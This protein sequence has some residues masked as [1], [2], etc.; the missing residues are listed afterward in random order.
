[1]KSRVPMDG[2]RFI[3]VHK[4]ALQLERAHHEL[5]KTVSPSPSSGNY[6]KSCSTEIY[7]KVL[8]SEL[9]GTSNINLKILEF[10]NN[11][12]DD[13]LCRKKRRLSVFGEFDIVPSKTASQRHIST[14]PIAVYDV[15]DIENDYYLN[16]VNWHPT[17]NL[18]AV[19]VKNRINLYNFDD[20]SVSGLSEIGIG[21][22]EPRYT[23]TSLRWIPR[24][25]MCLAIGMSNGTIEVWDVHKSA[26]LR[27]LHNHQSRVCSLSWNKN[28]LASGSSDTKIVIYDPLR[29]SAQYITQIQCHDQEVCSLEWSPDGTKLASGGNDNIV[30]VWQLHSNHFRAFRDHTAAVKALAWCPFKPSVLASG[31]GTADRHIC[32][33]DTN[34]GECINTVDTRSQVSSLRWSPNP[35][36]ELV[37]GHGFSQNS[38][39]VWECPSL[40][41]IAVLD[42][43]KDRILHTAQ[44]PRGNIVASVS[45]DG[46]MKTWNIWPYPTIES[47]R[48]EDRLLHSIMKVVR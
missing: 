47:T 44:S 21:G 39:L 3:P 9:F 15:G 5:L 18:L 6:V 26:K 11:N 27:K 28:L 29:S 8:F 32:L 45:A 35:Y 12:H 36:R 37:S 43:H 10:T 24:H 34:T 41:K 48:T 46:H 13:P 19:A 33:W 14:S 30:N 7:R 22:D 25:E 4:S 17:K 38:L 23:I 31:G 20:E 40:K 2:D 1:M 16:V 42:N